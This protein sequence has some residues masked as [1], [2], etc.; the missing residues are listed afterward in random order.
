MVDDGDVKRLER[1][2]DGEKVSVDVLA[3]VRDD[4]DAVVVDVVALF[5]DDGAVDASMGASSRGT[6][7]SLGMDF[8]RQGAGSSPVTE[9]AV[10]LGVA[11]DPETDE[12]LVRLL[13]D[14]WNVEVERTL[15]P[16]DSPDKTSPLDELAELA[17][18]T[19][20]GALECAL[21]VANVTLDV[22]IVGEGSTSTDN[23][24]GIC[25]PRRSPEEDDDVPVILTS[26]TL[27]Y[28]IVL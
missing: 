13:P 14:S 10:L 1:R 23:L 24:R 12:L 26:C 16:V 2:G 28:W 18:F 25:E 15:W 20:L 27:L 6:E 9:A 19:V 8:L 21:L 17:V 4:N 3:A 11:A 5:N 7:D 22:C